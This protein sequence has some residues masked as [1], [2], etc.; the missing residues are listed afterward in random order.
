MIKIKNWSSLQSYKDRTPPW[1]RLHKTLLD[2]Y[3][4]QSM[5]A[6][7]RALLPMLWLLAS[8]DKDPVSGLL[9]IGYE[10]VIYRLRMDMKLFTECL[11]EIK[12]ADFIELPETVTDSACNETVTDFYENV[13]PET[14]TETETETESCA[15]E[16]YNS[17]AKEKDL[18]IA[19]KLTST[20]KRKIHARLKDS[21]GIKGW[22]AAMDKLSASAFLTGQNNNNW[23]A[24]LDFVLQ[25]KSFIKLMEGSYDNNKAKDGS[26][27]FMG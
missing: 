17:V 10:E 13:T 1:I 12:K 7:S 25:E 3:K 22:D 5:S 19:Q 20:R 9:R 21:D 11:E 27:W 15:F 8:E 26:A 23:K 18:P 2:N 14:E 6:D 4:F 16:K 24:D